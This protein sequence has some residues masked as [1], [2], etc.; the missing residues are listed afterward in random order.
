M[1]RISVAALLLVCVWGGGAILAQTG[2][3]TDADS[4]R[5][6]VDET[7]GIEQR[8]QQKQDQWEKEKAQL[9]ARYRTAQANVAF[10]TDRKSVDQQKLAALEASIAEM[11]R[12]LEESDRLSATIQ[13]TMNVIA[14][15]LEEWIHEDLPFLME[16]RTARVDDL[17]KTLVQ[18]D[19]QDAEKLRRLLEVL[20]IEVNYGGTVEVNQQKIAVSGEQLFVDVLRIGRVSV[21]WRTP[22]GK[23]CGEFDRASREWVEFPGK[24]NRPIGE[25]M[26]MASRMRP[27]QL[28]SLPLG[29]IAP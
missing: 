24:Y 6:T 4:L 13:D 16:E 1:R 23:R 27:V 28:L 14:G 5:K 3:K 17:E 8:T 18:P 10:L 29:R 22:D 9:V 25:A 2:A 15:R 12:R 21:F 7:V 20:Q 26:E 19:V 11:H